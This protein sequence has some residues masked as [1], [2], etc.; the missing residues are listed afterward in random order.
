[1]HRRAAGKPIEVQL[2][3][4][5]RRHVSILRNKAV[6][7]KTPGFFCLECGVIKPVNAMCNEEHQ[8]CYACTLDTCC[9]GR[10]FKRCVERDIEIG[11]TFGNCPRCAR[12]MYCGSHCDVCDTT[13][14]CKC[15]G[16]SDCLACEE[17]AARICDECKHVAPAPLP[18]CRCDRPLCS[19]CAQTTEEPEFE[20]GVMCY[21]CL[22]SHG[23]ERCDGCEEWVLR[24]D[25]SH[26]FT[27]GFNLCPGC[28]H[29]GESCPGR[30]ESS[31]SE[32]ESASEDNMV[33]AG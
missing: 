14:C 20:N 9:V 18:R 32:D 27:C 1:V 2:T 8:V 15:K 30:E 5:H 26:C 10:V 7:E 24:Y 11:H 19:N 33:E 6:Y 21:A 12:V 16:E 13:V 22:D 3:L 31:S 25:R 4:L 17:Q 23:F 29:S 28:H